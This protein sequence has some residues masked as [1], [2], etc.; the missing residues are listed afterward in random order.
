MSG[1]HL[2]E[3][4]MQEYLDGMS[5]ERSAGIKEHLMKC[6][7]CRLQMAAYR[8]IFSGYDNEPED[9]FSDELEDNVIVAVG[10]TY[11]LK[12]QVKEILYYL[13]ITAAF[14]SP[15]I[16]IFIW[17]EVSNLISLSFLSILTTLGETYTSLLG[18]LQIDAI[19]INYIVVIG[20]F[21]VVYSLLDRILFSRYIRRE[22]KKHYQFD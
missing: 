3:N 14:L 17:G 11:S 15:V 2:T 10:N 9:I 5:G 7:S 19:N 16:I 20:I 8:Y 6:E 22:E 21:A 13:L 4:E 18:L 1:E 12:G